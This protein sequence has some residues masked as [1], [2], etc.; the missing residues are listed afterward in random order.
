M[1]LYGKQLDDDSYCPTTE[2]SY[3]GEVPVVDQMPLYGG[4]DHDG[5]SQPDASTSKDTIALGS[6]G[7]PGYEFE[8]GDL[9]R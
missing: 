2:W 6:A 7:G 1:P 5:P 4:G 3:P 9:P 8:K